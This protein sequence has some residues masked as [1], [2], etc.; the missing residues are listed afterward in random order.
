[1]TNKQLQHELQRENS[2]TQEQLDSYRK[3]ICGLEAAPQL[4]P[5]ELPRPAATP[6]PV[7]TKPAVAPV[8]SQSEGRRTANQGPTPIQGTPS[9][10]PRAVPKKPAPDRSRDLASIAAE[11][12][13]DYEEEASAVMPG[14]YARDEFI[15]VRYAEELKRFQG[16]AN[17]ARRADEM[18]FQFIMREF[19]L[20]RKDLEA[21][22]AEK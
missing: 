4:K 12:L 18:A 15:R 14:G 17:N 13:D 8:P 16:T 2:L 3:Q 7:A 22:L 1:G 9:T 11:A 20:K 6:V 5:T 10:A 19:S 21:I